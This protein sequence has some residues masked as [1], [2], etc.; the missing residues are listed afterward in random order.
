[1]HM[2]YIYK[3]WNIL[4]ISGLLYRI[5]EI[6]RNEKRYLEILSCNLMQTLIYVAILFL[7][8]KLKLEVYFKSY[9]TSLNSIFLQ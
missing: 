3:V 9:A 7:N 5:S 2:N 8:N 6:R 1:M 4:S